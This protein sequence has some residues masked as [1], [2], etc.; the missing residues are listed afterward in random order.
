MASYIGRRKFLVALGG[1]AAAWPLAARAQ[2]GQ[3]LTGDRPIAQRQNIRIVV[4]IDVRSG[5]RQARSP[6]RL[7]RCSIRRTAILRDAWKLP[8]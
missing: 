4:S 5:P 1:P 3:R 8:T 6:W 7:T 2:Q